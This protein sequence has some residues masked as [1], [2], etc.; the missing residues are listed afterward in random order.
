VLWLVSNAQAEEHAGVL[1]FREKLIAV[2]ID[3]IA[4]LWRAEEWSPAVED[5]LYENLFQFVE[6]HAALPPRLNLL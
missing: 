4:T 3:H 6:K 2:G 1:R 5:S